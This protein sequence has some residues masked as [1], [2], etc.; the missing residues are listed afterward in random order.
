MEAKEDE[1]RNV[2]NVKKVNLNSWNKQDY[3]NLKKAKGMGS[4]LRGSQIVKDVIS[5]LQIRGFYNGDGDYNFND[6]NDYNYNKV[7]QIFYGQSF[8]EFLEKNKVYSIYKA[9]HASV[10][11]DEE[12]EQSR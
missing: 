1:Q 4:S 9:E 11:R 10:G 8:K 5:N 3:E 7:F 2:L 12:S 6:D